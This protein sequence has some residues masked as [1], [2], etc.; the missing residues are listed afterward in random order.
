[1]AT[2]TITD[3]R[4]A[5]RNAA[6][7]SLSD[8]MRPA[9][10]MSSPAMMDRQP[11]PRTLPRERLLN[12]T[13]K[14]VA[15]GRQYVWLVRPLSVTTVRGGRK[16]LSVTTVRGG[17]KPLSVTTVR[18]GRK[19]LSVTTVRGGRKPLS[20]TTVRGERKRL[21]NCKILLAAVVAVSKSDNRLT[22]TTLIPSIITT[23]F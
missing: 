3:A 8:N 11:V 1:M 4:S 13:P 7:A 5:R 9:R 15:T 17:R 20:V 14:N 19:P 21:P 23:I 10:S 22:L 18:G 6:I 12:H 16:P 2:Q